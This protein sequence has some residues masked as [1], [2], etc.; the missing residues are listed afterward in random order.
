[1]NPSSQQ[2][3]PYPDEDLPETTL[4]LAR[5]VHVAQSLFTKDLDEFVRFV[6]ARPCQ[7]LDER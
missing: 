6:L 3:L 1:M 2:S 4:S 5:F 7:A